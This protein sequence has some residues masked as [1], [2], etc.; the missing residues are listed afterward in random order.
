MN[1][2]P[3]DIKVNQDVGEVFRSLQSSSFVTRGIAVKRFIAVG[4][5]LFGRKPAEGFWFF[6]ARTVWVECFDTLVEGVVD[7]PCHLV[8]RVG[9]AEHIALRVVGVSGLEV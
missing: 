9:E 7:V 5:Y 4:V 8:Q 3:L 6:K 2:L 1:F